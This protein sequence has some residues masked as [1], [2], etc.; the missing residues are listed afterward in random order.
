MKL[1]GDSKEVDHSKEDNL[2]IDEG[3][4]HKIQVFLQDSPGLIVIS[5]EAVD[6]VINHK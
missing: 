5:L 6:S 4:L 2:L 1:G 3:L